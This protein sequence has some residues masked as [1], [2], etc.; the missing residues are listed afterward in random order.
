MAREPKRYAKLGLLRV[1]HVFPALYI[2]HGL[3]M[4]SHM[5]TYFSFRIDGHSPEQE[6]IA[7]SPEN[8]SVS[9]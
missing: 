7:A 3:C 9:R 2:P 6:L 4:Q 5:C 1:I 8:R